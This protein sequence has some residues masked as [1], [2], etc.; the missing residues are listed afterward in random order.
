MQRFGW[1]LELQSTERDES[2]VSSDNPDHI[3][4]PSRLQLSVVVLHMV[5]GPLFLVPIEFGW[6]I[7]RFLAPT[8]L[9]VV[10]LGYFVPHAIV[11]VF[12]GRRDLKKA[13]DAEWALVTGAS[14]GRSHFVP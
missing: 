12:F 2:C 11:C 9:A 4:S 14:S 1:P 13:Y 10:L 5:L 3:E 8:V 6:Q 7:F